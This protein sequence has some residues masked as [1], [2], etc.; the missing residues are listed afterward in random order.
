M[1]WC[2]STVLTRFEVMN[3]TAWNKLPPDIQK[4]FQNNVG[5]SP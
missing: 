4:V 2:T 5:G 3:L 1:T